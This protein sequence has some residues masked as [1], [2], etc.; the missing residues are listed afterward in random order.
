M[1]MKQVNTSFIKEKEQ[2]KNKIQVIQIIQIIQSSPMR[3]Q[4][5]YKSTLKGKTN[6]ISGCLIGSPTGGR[7][8]ARSE[9]P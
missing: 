9:R 8:R 1:N 3:S 7:H 6:E 4:N 2:S 5:Q